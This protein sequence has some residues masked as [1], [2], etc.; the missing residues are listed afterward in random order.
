MSILQ[1]P[2]EE[3]RILRVVAAIVK[4]GGRVFVAR[5]AAHKSN[6]GRWEFPGGKVEGGEEPRAALRREWRE[7]FSLELHVGEHWMTTRTETSAG[8]LELAAYWASMPGEPTRASD[9]DIWRFHD[10]AA[11]ASLDLTDPDRPIAERLAG[12]AADRPE[13]AGDS[14]DESGR[15]A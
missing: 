14:D 8:S 15:S 1:Q 12:L 4:R 5:R 10:V 6:A 9:H 2:A 13:P 7:E 11:L 3:R